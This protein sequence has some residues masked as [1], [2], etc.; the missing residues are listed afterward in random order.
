MSGPYRF[1][2]E[3]ITSPLDQRPPNPFPSGQP[4][5]FKTNINR[6]KTKKWVEAKPFSYDGDDWG[7]YDE[8]D[9]YG[10]A[11]H[12]SQNPQAPTGLRQRGQSIGKGASRSFT[13]P[14][15]APAQA[16]AR[17]PS[18]EYGEEKRAFSASLNHSQTLPVQP[19]SLD[20]SAPGGN[21][22]GKAPA[23][24][25]AF[26][27]SP[28]QQEPAPSS[29]AQPAAGSFQEPASAQSRGSSTSWAPNPNKPLP[30]IRPA[31][32]YKRVEEE[33]RKASMDSERPSLDSVTRPS[34]D[35]MRSPGV[36]PAGSSEN[37]SRGRSPSIERYD[38]GRGQNL[39][40]L[41]TVAERKSEYLHDFSLAQ[42]EKAAKAEST[43]TP[44]A[45]PPTISALPHVPVSS[46]GADFWDSAEKPSTAS[47]SAQDLAEANKV[48]PQPEVG[49][50]DETSLHHQPSHGFRTAVRN[51]FERTDDNSCVQEQY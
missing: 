51:A 38:A 49:P 24:E 31:D 26:V 28:S 8:D 29:S 3:R 6:N 22:A 20:T 2:Q 27:E 48:L 46:F 25:P 42:A 43:P 44:A 40:P 14:A 41:E 1:G 11:A 21:A 9:E 4:V 15:Q 33:R 37:L 19:P 5:S 30:F 35:D 32:I 12:A 18:F 13:E 47:L 39:A 7:D 36:R 17:R 45:A 34:E 10:V 50:A 16:H 23:L